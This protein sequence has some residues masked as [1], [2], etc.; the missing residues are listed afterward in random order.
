[1]DADARAALAE[2]LRVEWEAAG[3]LTH[4][5]AT[6]TSLL[7]IIFWLLH[8]FW[9]LSLALC[10]GSASRRSAPP[11]PRSV[12]LPNAATSTGESAPLR[13]A[14]VTS[15]VTTFERVATLRQ[16]WQHTA[17]RH[18]PLPCMHSRL[19]EREVVQMESVTDPETGAQRMRE[20]V[21]YV[22]APR[23][24][25]VTYSGVDAI[26]RSV[27]AGLHHLLASTSTAA[28][29]LVAGTPVPIA[30]P[31]SECTP[32]ASRVVT[33][34]A[35]TKAEWMQTALGCFYGGI[36][37]AT[38]YAT[39]GLDALAYSV[40]LT[41]SAIIV[42]DDALLPQL[43]SIMNGRAFEDEGTMRAANTSAMRIVVRIPGS[44][45]PDAAAMAALQGRAREKGGPIGLIT[46]AELQNLGRA[47][48]AAEVD[49]PTPDSVAC[50][51]FTS[52]T[53]GLPKGVTMTHENM[54]ASVG[55]LGGSV[56]DLIPSDVYL[57]YLPLAHVLEL[58]AETALYA[59]GCSIGYSSPR[60]ITDASS[61]IPKEPVNGVLIRG[62]AVVLRPTLMA[63]VPAVFDRVRRG[64]EAQVRRQPAWR[65]KLF[66]VAFAACNAARKRGETHAL[67][68]ALVFD[69]IRTRAL[70]GRLRMMLSGGGPL[71]PDTEEFIATVLCAP[72]A[73]GYGLTETVAA[74]T[75]NWADDAVAGRVGPPVLCADI[76]LVDWPEAGYL[77]TDTPHP[78]GEVYIA[79]ACVSQGYFKNP[80]KTAE[81]FKRGA[82]GRT[83]FATGDIAEVQDGVL[84]IID[85]KK[86]LFKLAHGE[87]IAPAK[88]EG[89]LG[90]SPLVENIMIHADSMKDYCVAVVLPSVAAIKAVDAALVEGGLSTMAH[91]DAVAALIRAD[92]DRIA[93]EKK[94]AR[95]ETPRKLVV[96]DREWTAANGLLTESMKV[97][98]Y[99]IVRTFKAAIDAACR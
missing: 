69:A 45:P 41:G 96:S 92:I 30:L 23:Y 57:G 38:S 7:H 5:G 44:S 64:I 9:R 82:D 99:V 26:V 31:A 62:D 87:Y 83:W 90:A 20:E 78:R 56:P 35:E 51:M 14:R 75:I 95:V 65:Q 21:K 12:P 48:A 73:Q 66:Q 88:I 55:G 60:T 13:N 80:S 53:T 24:S 49:V 3:K 32:R 6:P 18:G 27:A 72:I 63:G 15:L 70:G 93:R 43:V 86:D 4:S 11:L 79:G 71:P 52:G 40:E 68:N 29:A 22:L 16:L 33:I 8:E 89:A 74:G 97:K 34:Y 58:V 77:H 28:D 36:T 47:A 59:Y 84:R 19:V 25:S 2:G 98:R 67:F 76:K 17:S 39:L 61:G 50:I 42:A 1:M 37:I 85:R 91:S 46:F 81:A 10:F 54:L 94:L